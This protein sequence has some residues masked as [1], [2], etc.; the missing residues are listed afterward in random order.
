[1][2]RNLVFIPKGRQFLGKVSCFLFYMYL[3]VSP[4]LIKNCNIF[5][6]KGSLTREYIR[7]RVILIILI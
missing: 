3:I 6:K 7:E 2:Q 4:D 1:M 5:V